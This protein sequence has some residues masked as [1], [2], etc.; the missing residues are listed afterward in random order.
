M[1]IRFFRYPSPASGDPEPQWPQWM[2]DEEPAFALVALHRSSDPDASEHD[3]ND[4]LGGYGD[5]AAMET[6]ADEQGV[7]MIG[8]DELP[9]PPA[10]YPAPFATAPVRIRARW[11]DGRYRGDDPETPDI[12]EAWVTP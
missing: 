4:Y 3:G 5:A 7:D 12:N 2:M 10:F 6:W 9:K 8:T 11:P 1:D